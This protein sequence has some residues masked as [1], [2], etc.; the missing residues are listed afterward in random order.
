GGV[1]LPQPERIRRHMALRARSKVPPETLVPLLQAEVTKLDKDL[2]I[3]NVQPMTAYVKKAQRETRFT[4]MLSG[5]LAL[6]ALVLAC[7]GI[8]GVTSY[9]VQRRTDELG[10]RIAV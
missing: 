2:P 6:V 7:T 1:H 4:T 5:A 9:S 8:Y 3:Y 10:K